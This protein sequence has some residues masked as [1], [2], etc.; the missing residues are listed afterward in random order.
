MMKAYNNANRAKDLLLQF[1]I[2]AKTLSKRG[3]TD[4][5]VYLENFAAKLMEIYYGYSFVNMN[6]ASK[7]FAGID[8]LN[9][10][11]NHGIQFTIQDNSTDKII[12]SIKK[13][14]DYSKI[15]VF[16]FNTQSV[17]TIVR[18]AKKREEWNDNVEVISLYDIFSVI[19]QDPI[20]ADLYKDLCELWI[21]GNTQNYTDL[22][23]E[24]NDETEKRIERNVRSKK[25]IPEIYIP[26][27][28]LKKT[29]RVFADPCWA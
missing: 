7:N 9:K 5:T 27:I 11:E 17:N 1:Q 10:Q 24:F 4:I 23:D 28:N 26:E 14:E 19:D 22:V 20:K 13:S 3:P 8:L 12:N 25:Y 18:H 16:F 29:C 2:Y 15:T 6:Y 21:N